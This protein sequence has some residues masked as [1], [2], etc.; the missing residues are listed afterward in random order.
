MENHAE[1]IMAAYRIRDKIR[2]ARMAKA[3]L[4]LRR[5][6]KQQ[7]SAKS[8]NDRSDNG[9]SNANTQTNNVPARPNA[10]LVPG[11]GNERQTE[12]GDE[13]NSNNTSTT[14]IGTSNDCRQLAPGR[15]DAVGR[16]GNGGTNR[17]TTNASREGWRHDEAY[18]NETKEYKEAV[19]RAINAAEQLRGA[20]EPLRKLDSNRN[21]EKRSSTSRWSPPSPPYLSA[22]SEMNPFTA[23]PKIPDKCQE[24]H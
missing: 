3:Y 18:A 6:V 8:P 4:C 24:T 13:E 16:G 12:C 20:I 14:Q 23:V 10:Q 22:A 21:A 17:Y 11:Q 15:G 7:C 9:P 1:S 2:E 5:H 19:A